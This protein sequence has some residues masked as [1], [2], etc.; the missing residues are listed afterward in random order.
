MPHD[1]R[2]NR[3]TLANIEG[4]AIFGIKN[5]DSRLVREILN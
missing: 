1:P 4:A 3:I 5:I 2:F